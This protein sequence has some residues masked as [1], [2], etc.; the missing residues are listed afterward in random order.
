MPLDELKSIQSLWEKLAKA[1]NSIKRPKTEA[2]WDEC[3]AV[4]RPASYI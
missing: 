1:Y 3:V 4:G 2:E